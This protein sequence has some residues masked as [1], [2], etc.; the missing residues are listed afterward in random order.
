MKNLLWSLAAFLFTVQACSPKMNEENV[1]ATDIPADEPA[2]EVE[3]H[4][5]D[6]W[7]KKSQEGIDFI[8]TGNEPFW[9]V[10]ID[11][12]K[13]MT[14][15]TM[16]A[17]DK[18]STP[19]PEPIRPQDVDAISYRA[20]TDKGNLYVTLFKEK[21]ADSMSGLESPYRVQVSFKAGDSDN[22]EEY[23]GCGR[24]LGNYRLNDIW[25]LTHMDGNALSPND[26]PKGVPTLELQLN[27]GKVFGNSGCNQM[28]GSIT[29]RK[30]ALAF[31][32]LVSTKMACPALQ[33]ET[34]YLKA[35]SGNTLDYKLEGLILQLSN[36]QHQLTFKKVD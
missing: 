34:R 29:L 23:T 14:F 21:C 36:D 6:H 13:S 27:A 16:D 11:F 12:E 2:T 15:S 28:S 17:P 18:M 9:S 5:A 7:L 10:E 3:G 35:L 1:S 19:V 4:L 22:Y 30:D 25:A 26:F 31:G 20:N 8:A 24:Y 32:Q 33:F